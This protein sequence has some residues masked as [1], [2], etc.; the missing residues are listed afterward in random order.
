MA[1]SLLFF[2]GQMFG[3]GHTYI[4]RVHLFIHK[5][6]TCAMACRRAC[7]MSSVSEDVCDDTITDGICQS[8]FKL[9][10]YFRYATAHSHISYHG[11]VCVVLHHV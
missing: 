1:N 10:T 9:A 2:Y 4:L 8:D 7:S 6:A 5:T 3:T 11:H